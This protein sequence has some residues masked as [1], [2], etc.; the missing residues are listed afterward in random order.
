MKVVIAVIVVLLAT[1]FFCG[2]INLG[3]NSIFGH[4]DNALG[5]NFFMRVH[6]LTYWFLYSGKQKVESEID[7]TSKRID[8]F[9]ERPAGIDNKKY[10]RKL[11]EASQD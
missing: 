8:N 4:I 3:G 10:Y 7:G 2:S 1:I 6:Y 5:I 9:A 11:D